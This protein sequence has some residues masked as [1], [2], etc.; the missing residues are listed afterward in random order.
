[1]KDQS[2]SHSGADGGSGTMVHG[3][4]SVFGY[5]KMWSNDET[6]FYYIA[7]TNGGEN[8]YQGSS[9]TCSQ[10]YLHENTAQG[11]YVPGTTHLVIWH[12]RLNAPNT[13]PLRTCYAATVL[14]RMDLFDAFHAKLLIAKA[15]ND[16]TQSGDA[17]TWT[18]ETGKNVKLTVGFPDTF[19]ATEVNEKTTTHWSAWTSTIKAHAQARFHLRIAPTDNVQFN[20]FGTVTEI[21]TAGTVTPKEDSGK[22]QG[23]HIA[24]A[25]GDKDVLALFNSE[26]SAN[27]SSTVAG[28][29]SLDNELDVVRFRET[30]FTITWTPT[31][32]T[33]LVILNDLNPANTWT[34]TLDGGASTPITEETNGQWSATIAA[35]SGNP[36]T[37][38]VTGS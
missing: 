17:F 34:Y 3:F 32:A 13:V 15:Y 30:G 4:A 29:D 33:T 12:H 35:S 23:F 8:T 1:M 16:P 28:N 14:A 36:H 27:L 19:T 38:V 7:G 2:I 25:S 20:T 6:D 5:S 37:I 11:I 18:S 9:T 10:F 31:T 24:R 22:V 26:Q 21:G